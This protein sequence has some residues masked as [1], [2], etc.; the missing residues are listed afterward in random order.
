MTSCNRATH[1]GPVNIRGLERWVGDHSAERLLDVETG[2]SPQK[3]AIVGGG[4]AGMA[5]AFALVR[6]GHNV[7]IYDSQ[8]KLGGVL[9]SA[10]PSYRLPEDALDRDIRRIMQL[11]LKARCGELLDERRV[12]D[13]AAAYDALVVATGRAR[14]RDLDCAGTNLSGVEQGLEFLRR[15]KTEGAV[16]IAGAAIVIGGGNTAL[17]CAR[18]AMRCGATK[19]SIL[20]RRGR[21]EM[22]AIEEEIEETIAEGVELIL[23][24]QPVRFQ[25][26]GR[27]TG[28]EFAEV[29]LGPPD[30]SGRR[31]PLV[32]D[33]IGSIPCDY[34]LLAAGQ[35][36]D[37]E[38]FPSQWTIEGGRA[39]LSNQPL[40]IWLAGDLTTG[41]GTVANAIGHGRKVAEDILEYLANRPMADAQVSTPVPNV[42][43][44]EDIRFSHFP[45]TEPH[46]DRH[47]PVGSRISAFHE[48]N[49]GL[50]NDMEAQRCFSCG[51]CTQCDTCLTY[52]PEGI[53]SRNTGGY[54]INEE[55]CKGCGICA[56]ECPRNAMQMTAQGYRSRP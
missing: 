44:A 35:Y 2:L 24:R 8:P 29:N 4:P 52:C 18:T 6:A 40:N 45:L 51:L 21:E 33:R 1:D 36:A 30:A 50:V 15:A 48:V 49:M 10:I 23:H 26:N 5:A 56:W 12:E 27:V 13:L 47:L 43:S 7:T 42:A 39:Y 31:R 28:I 11:G 19:V 37:P 55:Y 25:G 32:T 17:D 3:M 38:I 9:R 54:V 22:P 46:Q 14:S 20:Y 41:A 16:R 34:V 53:I